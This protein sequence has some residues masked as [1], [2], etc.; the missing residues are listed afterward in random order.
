MPGHLIWGNSLVA[1]EVGHYLHNL[2]WGKQGF[3]ALKL[4]MSKAYDYVE[5]SFF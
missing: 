1:S 5:W 3:L 4:D 2:Q